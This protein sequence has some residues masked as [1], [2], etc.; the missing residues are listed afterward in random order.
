M[1]TDDILDR[2]ELEEDPNEHMKL[3]SGLSERV[4]RLQP[5]TFIMKPYATALVREGISGVS[6]R[7]GWIEER[8]LYRRGGDH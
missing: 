3:L 4:R 6:V 5:M 7:D 1:E 2:L 8:K